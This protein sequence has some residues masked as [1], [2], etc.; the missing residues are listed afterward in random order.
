MNSS[1]SDFQK[2]NSILNQNIKKQTEII[3]QYKN[4]LM[5]F[6]KEETKLIALKTKKENK[7]KKDDDIIKD[8]KNEI[9]NIKECLSNLNNNKNEFN[10]IEGEKLELEKENNQNTQIINELQNKIL[11]LENKLYTERENENSSLTDINITDFLNKNNNNNTLFIT[12]NELV[13]LRDKNEKLLKNIEEKKATQS[14]F[15]FISK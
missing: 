12:G 1:I 2:E 13:E 5:E 7:I 8:L 3:N 4:K 10:E 14:N 15:I 9:A 6:E 11:E